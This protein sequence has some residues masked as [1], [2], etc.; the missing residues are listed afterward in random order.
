VVLPELADFLETSADHGFLGLVGVESH[1]T[2][3]KH[4]SNLRHLILVELP[5]SPLLLLQI[6]WDALPAHWPV[7]ME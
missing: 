2:Y 7:K 1:G 4:L 5:S 3:A 6:L